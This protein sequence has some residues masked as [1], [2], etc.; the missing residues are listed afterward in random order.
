MHDR[1]RITLA[2]WA[3]IGV[4]VAL[5]GCGKS[6]APD[7]TAVF[8]VHG[9][10]FV[11]GKPATGAVV[12]FHPLGNSNPRALRANGRVRDDGSFLLTTYVTG[13]GAPQGDYVVTV[14][15]ADPA[16]KPRNEDEE[17]DLPP[18]LL[19][20][21]FAKR[22]ASLL[23]AKVGAKPNEFVPVDLDSSEVVKSREYHLREK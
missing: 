5:V 4:L 2:F 10:I 11:A 23:R 15:W 19:K 8:P 17:S 9:A 20:G 3:S 22:E 21:R 6:S 14:Y 7:R 13:D 18:D 1:K 12:S 16:K